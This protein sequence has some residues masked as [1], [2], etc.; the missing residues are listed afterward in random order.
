MRIIKSIQA[1]EEFLVNGDMTI[2]K[3]DTL[4]FGLESK[5]SLSDLN[6]ACNAIDILYVQYRTASER[7]GSGRFPT[8]LIKAEGKAVEFVE[9]DVK[10][11]SG[12]VNHANLE[13]YLNDLKPRDDDMEVVIC[14]RMSWSIRVTETRIYCRRRM[15]AMLL[16][17]SAKH[18]VEECVSAM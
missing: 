17:R 14:D 12:L 7:E 11:F 4:A 5:V 9:N 6:S 8:W 3:H 16:P 10:T 2:M 13:L 18:I 1:W 15:S